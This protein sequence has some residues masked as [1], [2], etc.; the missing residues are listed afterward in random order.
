MGA[1]TQ[2]LL[3][4]VEYSNLA[5]R[6]HT[7]SVQLQSAH[8]LPAAAKGSAAVVYVIVLSE[9]ISRTNDVN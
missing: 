6:N 1:I 8:W 2:L 7:H 9:E 3:A 4:A 5:L